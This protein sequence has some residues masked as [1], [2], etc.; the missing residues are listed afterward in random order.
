MH[1]IL[2]TNILVSA[3]F[4]STSATA[5]VLEIAFQNHTVLASSKTYSELEDVIWREKFDPY[6]TQAERERFLSRFL[7]H[8]RLVTT[9]EKITACRDPKDN[10]ILELAV[11]GKADCIIT[12]DKD[13]LALNPFRNI[14]I[15][16]SAAFLKLEI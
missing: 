7:K 16:T 6:I 2:D 4:S 12:G 10:M 1:I 11:A 8:T 3:S 13:L 9:N 5:K 14:Q 15:V